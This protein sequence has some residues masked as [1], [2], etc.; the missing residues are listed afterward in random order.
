MRDVD[1][2]PDILPPD[3]AHRTKKNILDDGFKPHFLRSS[4]PNWTPQNAQDK[5]EDQDQDKGT[6]AVSIRTGTWVL[7]AC[8][9]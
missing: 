6:C 2:P 3:S 9:G 8:R 1:S 7:E 4:E 5:R